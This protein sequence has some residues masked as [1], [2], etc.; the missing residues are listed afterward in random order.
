MATEGKCE[1]AYEKGRHNANN[2]DLNR[3]FPDQFESSLKNQN[4]FNGRQPE[5]VALMNWIL[6]NK[7]FV[8][9][10]N[11]HGGAVV[12]SYPYDDSISHQMT[13]VYSAA[14]DDSVFRH[15]ALTY[16][17]SHR[18]MHKGNLCGEPF[19]DG[20][21]NGAQW[22]DVPGGMQDF[23]YMNSN[24]MEITLELSCCKYPPASELVTE[25]ENNREALLN[26]MSQVHIGVKG[27]VVEGSNSGMDKNGV[28]GIPIQNARI[29]VEGLNHDV[30]SSNFGD[31]W[32]LLMPGKYKLT[33][34]ANGYKSQT[35]EVEV[36]TEK[37]SFLN[38][39]LKRE[40]GKGLHEKIEIS[41]SEQLEIL[42]SKINLLSD[43]EKRD[44]L[45]VNSVEPRPEIFRHHN[46]SKLVELFKAVK[47][48]CPTITSDYS[49]GQSWNGANIYAMII[50]D[51]PLIHE[52]GE[53]EFKY[54]ANMVNSYFETYISIYLLF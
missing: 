29:S 3:D 40:A 11:L 38:F 28:M 44:A 37:V 9:S 19:N 30:V 13:G 22:Y 54:V 4:M 39:T 52:P 46:H 20:I 7:R 51:N 27:F 25:W 24:C 48:K 53:P 1:G 26:Y 2:V 42:V 10:A 47:T 17:K 16:S 6:E 18:T 36:I 12:A 50:S 41:S 5:T 45:F 49:I 32:R 35:K 33:A 15:L 31:Y 43:T 23:N 34:Q 8:L 14:P 21:T